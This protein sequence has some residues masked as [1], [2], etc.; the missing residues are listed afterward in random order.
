MNRRLILCLA[1]CLN[2]FTVHA[3]ETKPLQ[4]VA[5]FS[6]LADMAREVAGDVAMV[7]SL[8]S[9]NADAHVFEPTPKDAQ[10]L[11][12]ADLVIVNGLRFE[13]WMDRLVKSSGYKGPVVVAT[14][15]IQPRLVR[16]SA[17]PHAWQSLN[18]AQTYVRNIAQALSSARPDQAAAIQARAASYSQKL[19]ALDEDARQQLAAVPPEQRRVITSH[20][21]FAYLG[22]AYGITFIAPQGWT[23]SNDAS[24]STVAAAIRQIKAKQ[25]RALFVENITD[26]RLIDRIAAETGAVVGGTLYSDALSVPGTEADTYLKLY[27]HNLKQLLTA[28]RSKP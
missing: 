4:V 15:G 2:S 27:A 5:S 19:K 1:L 6:I 8:V 28:L 3:N 18:H 14:N 12:T 17:D 16:T 23:T 20:D 13:G 7:T 9:P 26:R 10:R 21:A 22:E 24:A 25:A 11:K